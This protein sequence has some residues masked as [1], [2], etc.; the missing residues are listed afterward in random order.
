MPRKSTSSSKRP[1]VAGA[2]G[3]DPVG[4][5]DRAAAGHSVAS[6]HHEVDQNLLE[7]DRRAEHFSVARAAP[8]DEADARRQ[9]RAGEG[10]CFIYQSVEVDEFGPFDFR[11]REREQPA[12]EFRA[13]LGGM[14][15]FVQQF[16]LGA[17]L[18]FLVEEVEV[19]EDRREEVVEVVGDS[20]R[21]H[22]ETFELLALA[23]LLL[24]P[25]ALVVGGFPVG[26]VEKCPGGAEGPPGTISQDRGAASE[27]P[28]NM[29]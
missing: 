10:G 16:G 17:V 6:V 28:K 18:H 24:E 20:A 23:D 1:A 11:P 29:D 12:D 19:P 2:D 3:D 7:G 22:P 9:H 8:D 21:E 26:D 14:P 5:G 27:Q 15:R 25:F 4:D 13:S